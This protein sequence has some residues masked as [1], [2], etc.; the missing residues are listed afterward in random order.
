MLEFSRFNCAQLLLH[1]LMQ[2]LAYPD[3]KGGS[4]PCSDW[5]QLWDSC[6][7][8]ERIFGGEVVGW[9]GWS[10]WRQDRYLPQ[11]RLWPLKYWRFLK[12]CTRAN[13]LTLIKIEAKVRTAYG[14][15]LISVAPS[16]WQVCNQGPIMLYWSSRPNN[17]RSGG[18]CRWGFEARIPEDWVP[19]GDLHVV[20]SKEI[21]YESM[22]D[23]I[24]D[25]LC[26]LQR[27]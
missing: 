24:T 2:E 3:E 14:V 4:S 26:L 17:F 22:S 25:L 10:D 18:P 20:S 8:D 11:C 9:V 12:V 21:Q 6:K 27:L 7:N 1:V 13:A 19:R 16:L 23:V 15:A 5:D